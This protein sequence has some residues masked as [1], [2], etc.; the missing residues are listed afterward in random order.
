M[1]RTIRTNAG[2]DRLRTALMVVSAL[3]LMGLTAFPVCAQ[4]AWP[5]YPSNTAISVTGGGNVGMGT[6]TPGWPLSVR[7]VQPAQLELIGTGTGMSGYTQMIFTGTGRGWQLGV[8]NSTETYF[9]VPNKFYVYDGGSGSMRIAIDTLG[10]VG[11]G[12]TNPQ[13][14]LAVNGTIGA[15]DVIVTNSGWADYVFQPGYRLRPLSEISAFIEKHR[16]L[17]DIPSE[18]EVNEK[19]VSVGEMQVKLLAK[20]EELTLHLIQQEQENRSLRE[21]LAELE[22]R[23][24]ASPVPVR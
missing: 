14:R 9:G 11:I 12:T 4:S 17:R 21:R 16:H 2:I 10:N 13:Y 19:G 1:N 7:S 20:V 15:K 5:G 6:A 3:A 8:G 22:N 23:V 24:A 18:A